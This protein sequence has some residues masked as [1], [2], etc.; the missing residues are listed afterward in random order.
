MLLTRLQSE[1][2]AAGELEWTLSVD[3]TVAR[4]HQHSAEA[5]RAPSKQDAKGGV[6]HPRDEAIG[7]GRGGLSTKIHISCDGKGRPLSVILSPSQRHESTQFEAVL[8]SVRVPKPPGEPG[9]PRKLPEV[10]L[11]D[12]G[13]SFPA[14]R[15]YLRNKGVSHVISEREDQK[16]RR[17]EHPGRKPDFNRELYA[18]RN[19]V[20]RCLNKLKRWRA[21]ATRYDK[22][23]TN[24]R[25]AITVASLSI[26]LT[27]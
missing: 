19:V 23:A 9:R 17:S 15:L 25:A 4:A 8:D 7:K 20:E 22:R 18:E 24:Y 21:I 5:R 26:W 2:D 6:R 14:C 11:A 12:R 10:V 13:Y 3:S 1:A 16:K 27:S